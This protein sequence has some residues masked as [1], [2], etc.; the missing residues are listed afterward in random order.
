MSLMSISVFIIA[1][2]FVALVVFLSRTLFSLEKVFKEIEGTLSEAQ[3]DLQSVSLEAK[4][5]LH[6]SNQLADEAKILIRN[7]NDLTEEMRERAKSLDILAESVEG[8]GETIN[9][10]NEKVR[11]TALSVT[12]T[13]KTSTEKFAQALKWGTTAA[14][15]WDKIKSMR[16][17]KKDHGKTRYNDP[18]IR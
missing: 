8:I 16:G 3:K 1:I 5:F 7:T 12:D 9:D 14:D 11:G 18:T 2:A 17:G 4:D 10:L 13:V 15:I 6:T